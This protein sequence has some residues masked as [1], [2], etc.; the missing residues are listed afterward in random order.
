LFLRRTV[1][2]QTIS[3]LKVQD[4]QIKIGSGGIIGRGS[5]VA[6]KTVVTK[7][8]LFGGP[9]SRRQ[10]QVQQKV[11]ILTGI[12]DCQEL[13]AAGRFIRLTPNGEEAAMTESV[14]ESTIVRQ[15]YMIH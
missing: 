1:T 12:G 5:V 3:L 9:I 8:V 6:G 14:L 7:K 11:K 10:N 13:R 4:C 15:V 2:V